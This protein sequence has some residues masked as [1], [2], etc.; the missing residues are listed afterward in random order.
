MTETIHG[1]I[2]Y[3]LVGIVVIGATYI[4]RKD[5]INIIK[6]Q[7][8]LFLPPYNTVI[9]GILTTLLIILFPL[10]LLTQIVHTIRHINEKPK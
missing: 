3:L 8:N 4:L 6:E 9:F 2:T 7:S 10:V 5:A 1:T